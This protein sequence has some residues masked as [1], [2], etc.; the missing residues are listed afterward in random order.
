ML[1]ESCAGCAKNTGPMLVRP[2]LGGVLR[3]AKT[4]S[5][6]YLGQPGKE[7]MTSAPCRG[8]DFHTLPRMLGN[9]H[10][11]QLRDTAGVLQAYLGIALCA[12][13]YPS[14]A[15]IFGKH[16]TGAGRLNVS[17]PAADIPSSYS[18]GQP[19]FSLEWVGCSRQSEVKRGFLL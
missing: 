11:L 7:K 2:I 15:L 13:R 1:V 17:P 8:L 6:G 12:P 16:K 4:C 18:L 3:L 9:P 19:I 10:G 14:D 5:E